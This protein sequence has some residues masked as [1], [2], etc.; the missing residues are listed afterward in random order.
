MPGCGKARGRTV[1]RIIPRLV[2]ADVAGWVHGRAFTDDSLGGAK[3]LGGCQ[4]GTGEVT[5]TEVSEK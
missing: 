5:H 2:V 3:D 1:P 4:F